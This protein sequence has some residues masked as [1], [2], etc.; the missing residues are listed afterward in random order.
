[1]KEIEEKTILA[2]YMSKE[3]RD[4]IKE[5]AYQARTSMNGFIKKLVKDY[6]KR[7][8]RKKGKK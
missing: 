1:M 4:E 5:M 2:L 3:E 7:E 6:K 8:K